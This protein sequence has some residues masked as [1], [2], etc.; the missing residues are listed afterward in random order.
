MPSDP[1]IASSDS[2]FDS[3]SSSVAILTQV[4]ATFQQRHNRPPAPTVVTAL[5]TA[6]KETRQHRLSYPPELL[7]GKWRLCF[8]APRQAHFKE[9]KAIGKGF[10]IPQIAPAQISFAPAPGIESNP[11]QMTIG[12]QV[13][14]GPLVLRFTGP[15]RYAAKK[16]LLAF[17]FTQIQLSA[18]GR[19]LYQGSFRSGKA[20]TK[21]FEQQSIAKL[22]FFAFFMLT[23]S[24]I[25][26]RGR[27]GGLALWVKE[28][29]MEG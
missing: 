4:A 13:Q 24:F 1:F 28:G 5:L 3:L 20:Q 2:S 17:D 9:D 18:F 19:T 11:D 8:T 22:P 16:N 27:G 26:A 23:D 6:E 14:A 10:Y 12:N 7:F 21:N 15:A 29:E 25:A